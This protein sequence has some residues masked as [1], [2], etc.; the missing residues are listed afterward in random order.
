MKIVDTLLDEHKSYLGPKFD[1]IVPVCPSPVCTGCTH[2]PGWWLDFMPLLNLCMSADPNALLQD[3][4]WML[5]WYGSL[6]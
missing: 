3:N 5:F 4:L 2:C 1:L 6:K